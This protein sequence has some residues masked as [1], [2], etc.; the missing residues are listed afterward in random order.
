MK[1]N[2]EPDLDP[3]CSSLYPV[4][5]YYIRNQATGVSLARDGMLARYSCNLVMMTKQYAEKR[6]S[7]QNVKNHF[8]MKMSENDHT[9]S[10]D[11]D[12]AQQNVWQDPKEKGP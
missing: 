12:Q 1:K 4:S 9:N 7:M 3:N 6:I 11:P 5:T 10:L 2:L 8:K